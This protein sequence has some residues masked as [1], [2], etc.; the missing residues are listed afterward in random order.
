MDIFADTVAGFGSRLGMPGLAL[1]PG[2]SVDLSIE[3][4]GRLQLEER[5]GVALVT[6][7]RKRREH[8][9][10]GAATMLRL[11][12]WREN[13]PWTIHPGM[14]GEEWA[15]FTASVPVNE[16]DV[17]ALERLVGYLAKLMD[18]VEQAG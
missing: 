6:L 8:A 17:P 5:N 18:A 13:H 10:N 16:L 4:I 7:A 12:H 1:N 14:K 15:A 3:R 11:A 2:G 9:E